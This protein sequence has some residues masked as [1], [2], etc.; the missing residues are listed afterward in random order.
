MSHLYFGCR[1]RRS[2]EHAVQL[3]DA[4]AMTV[5]RCFTFCAEKQNT[6]FFGVEDGR[7]CWCAP[8]FNGGKLEADRCDVPCAGN[9]KEKCGGVGGAASVHMLFNCPATPSHAEPP[10]TIS[11]SKIEGRTCGNPALASPAAAGAG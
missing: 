7:K 1:Q 6:G 11:Y 2:L 9:Q 8:T 10:S 4:L 3:E 5:D